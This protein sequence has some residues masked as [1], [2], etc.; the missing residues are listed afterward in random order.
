MKKINL[1]TVE[2]TYSFTRKIFRIFLKS[3]VLKLLEDLQ[4]YLRVS[5]PIYRH[6][7]KTLTSKQFGNNNY[8]LLINF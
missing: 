8:L 2:T 7:S 4:L 5:L 3:Q 6:I 1:E